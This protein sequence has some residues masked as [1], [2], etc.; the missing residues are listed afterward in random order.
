MH[1][2]KIDITK[3][4]L[5]IPDGKGYMDFALTSPLSA[6][7]RSEGVDFTISETIQKKSYEVQKVSHDRKEIINYLIPIDDRRLFT[8]LVQITD[9]RIN[10]LVNKKT[11]RFAEILDEELWRQKSRIKKLSWY[12]RLLNKF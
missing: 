9:D 3:E 5:E 10:D 11:E 6:K 7:L 2:I 8:D 4:D 1:V 12:K